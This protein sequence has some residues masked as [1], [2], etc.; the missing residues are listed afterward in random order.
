MDWQKISGRSSHKFHGKM[1]I[2]L[3]DGFKSHFIAKKVSSLAATYFFY[4]DFPVW[5]NKVKLI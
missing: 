2:E 4:S 5:Q 3:L 1:D